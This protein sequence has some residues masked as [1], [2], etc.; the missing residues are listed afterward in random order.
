MDYLATSGPEGELTEHWVQYLRS[1]V[2][3]PQWSTELACAGLQDN[4]LNRT[5]LHD[6]LADI[7]PRGIKTSTG[8]LNIKIHT[9]W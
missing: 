5:S 9:G 7:Y 2:D 6:S 4:H 1:F 3:H 8:C